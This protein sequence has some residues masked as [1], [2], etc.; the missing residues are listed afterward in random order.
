MTS[1]DDEMEQL[2]VSVPPEGLA[3]LLMPVFLDGRDISEAKLVITAEL[4]KRGANPNAIEPSRGQTPLM[5]ASAEGNSPAAEELIEFGAHVGTKSKSGFTPLL[6]AVRNAHIETVKTLLKH[7]ANVNDVA[8]DGTNAL[9]IAVVNAYFELASVLL[10]EG[11]D[12]VATIAGRR[13]AAA[14]RPARQQAARRGK[15]EKPSG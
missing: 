11:A 4:L 15:V 12:G 1:Q 5:W 9:N 7:G 6:F 10:D 8:P 3:G 2:L 14:S 13:Q